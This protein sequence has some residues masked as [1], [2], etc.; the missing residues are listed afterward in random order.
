MTNT[1]RSF[2]IHPYFKSIFEIK[3]VESLYFPLELI[4][5]L[6]DRSLG[7]TKMIKL[8]GGSFYSLSI[9]LWHFQTMGEKESN[10]S[11]IVNLTTLDSQYNE[12]A[13]DLKLREY[14]KTLMTIGDMGH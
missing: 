13:Q 1:K 7:V 4:G 5:I 14:I 2:Q 12:T 6:G 11:F 10:L 8:K 9:M 3:K